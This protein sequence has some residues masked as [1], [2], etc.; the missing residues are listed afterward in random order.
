MA[1]EGAGTAR[2]VTARTSRSDIGWSGRD[3]DDVRAPARPAN[4]A[5]STSASRSHDDPV[6]TVVSV[7]RSVVSRRCVSCSAHPKIAV[8]SSRSQTWGA[9]PAD[10]MSSRPILTAGPRS[11]ARMPSA[12]RYTSW[13]VSNACRRPGQVT[14]EAVAPRSAICGEVGEIW[15]WRSVVPRSSPA[16]TIPRACSAIGFGGSTCSW[17]RT[18]GR[19]SATATSPIAT[20]GRSGGAR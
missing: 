11:R 5:R 4:R 20:G 2:P 15:P 8:T 17:A 16:S 6:H 19:C 3:R 14:T 18:A 12:G 13:L 1:G 10:R 7:P 9:C